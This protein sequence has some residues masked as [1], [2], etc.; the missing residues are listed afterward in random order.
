MAP[1]SP[2]PTASLTCLRDHPL[3]VLLSLPPHCEIPDSIAGLSR[4]LAQ[5]L[6][7]SSPSALA[8]LQGSASS[9]QR[10]PK[11]SLCFPFL[12]FALSASLSPDAFSKPRSDHDAL[13]LTPSL[14]PTALRITTFFPRRTVRPSLPCPAHTP[15]GLLPPH[16]PP[17]ALESRHVGT[18][19][20]PYQA[21]PYLGIS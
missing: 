13:V 14:S 15:T 18:Y 10:P 7:S 4:G 6:P 9:L 2:A 11:H 21:L 17:L 20:V 1:P 16:L 19:S 5:G 8:R 3:H 12:P